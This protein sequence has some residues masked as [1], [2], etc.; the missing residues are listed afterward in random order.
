MAPKIDPLEIKTVYVRQTGGEV[1][2]S[3][4]LAPKLGPLGMSP[5][6]VGEDIAKATS[7]WK[8]IKVMVK[9]TVQNRQAKIDVVPTATSQVMKALKEPPRDR[10]KVKNIK[11]SGNL[12]LDN[13]IA[14]GR[15]MRENDRGIIARELKGTVKEVL[16]TCRAIG[17]TVDKK[18]PQDV[19]SEINDGSVD[20]PEE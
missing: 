20:I 17:C 3:A 4:V 18:Q 12:T 16:G 14:I 13:I 5:K 7:D 10:K 9:L 8:G 6:K 1:G 19:I 15:V 2:A 11:H